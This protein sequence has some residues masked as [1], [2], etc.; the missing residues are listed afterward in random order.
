MNDVDNSRKRS[1]SSLST[2]DPEVMDAIYE[3]WYDACDKWGELQARRK[4]AHVLHE[5]LP[6]GVRPKKSILKKPSIGGPSVSFVEPP[7]EPP[8]TSVSSPSHSPP[9]HPRVEAIVDEAVAQAPMP[10]APMPSDAEMDDLANRK[11]YTAADAQ[12]LID[13]QVRLGR[14][15]KVEAWGMRDPPTGDAAKPATL[16][17]MEFIDGTPRHR[18]WDYKAELKIAGYGHWSGCTYAGWR[19]VWTVPGGATV[20]R[21]GYGKVIADTHRLEVLHEKRDFYTAKPHVSG[22][23][24]VYAAKHYKRADYPHADEFGERGPQG[25]RWG[26]NWCGD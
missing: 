8:S 17:W 26:S 2:D 23:G 25:P 7:S 13:K 4:F 11:E 21:D 20:T 1:H 19:G 16:H 18:L 10:L 3:A 14:W 5:P 9:L 22:D 24:W 15:V 6:A 12:E